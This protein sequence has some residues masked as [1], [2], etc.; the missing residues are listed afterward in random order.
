[1]PKISVYLPDELADAVRDAQVPVSA[2]CQSALERAVREIAAARGADDVPPDDSAPGIGLFSRFTPRAR[3]A[4]TL[5]SDLSRDVPHTYVGTEHV[6]LGILEEGDNVAIATLGRLDVDLD[7][8]RAALRDTMTPA[9]EVAPTG[10]IPFTPRT[11]RALEMAAKEAL[12]LGHNYLGCEHLLLGLLAVDDGLASRVL[13]RMGVEPRT[14]RLAV[15]AELTRV[16][17][18][19]SSS[20]VG[21]TSPSSAGDATGAVLRQILDRLDA[22]EQRLDG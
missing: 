11:K 5:A 4:V 14:T 16:P 1:M 3:R 10:H 21:R 17:R 19:D 6:L 7:E 13:R 22:I 2:V 9:S 8:L 18:P 15:V 20:R 12:A